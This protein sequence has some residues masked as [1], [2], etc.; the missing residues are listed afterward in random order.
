MLALRCDGRHVDLLLRTVVHRTYVSP[1]R[2][3]QLPEALEGV[4]R[5]FLVVVA[6]VNK[7]VQLECCGSAPALVRVD[8]AVQDVDKAVQDVEL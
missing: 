4:D 6:T 3:D 1:C 7:A 2:A 8:K 5:D